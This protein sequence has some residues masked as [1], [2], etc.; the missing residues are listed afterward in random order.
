M[1]NARSWYFF[2]LYIEL[3]DTTGR[4]IAKWNGTPQIDFTGDTNNGGSYISYFAFSVMSGVS[5]YD[6]FIVGDGSGTVNTLPTGD[7]RVEYLVPNGV[8]AKTQFTPSAG[9][10]WGNV[11]ETGI[12]VD[13]DY[14]ASA[15]TGAVDLFPVSDLSG[16]GLIH[17]VQPVL[18][19]RK[20]DAGYR[21]IRPAFYKP[22]G[23]GDTPRLY[24]GT[25]QT[26][27]DNFAYNR[28]ILEF[29]PDTGVAWTTDEL[30]GM[31][32][33]YGVAGGGWIGVDAWIG[34]YTP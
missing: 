19:V 25:P 18:R 30:A 22:L 33:G 34:E 31:N 12:P 1:A 16:N 17:A 2:E 7:S 21:M 11:D 13:T 27:G 32:F 4:V 3:H 14:N 23:A 5:S 26:V 9:V 6:D 29:S 28:Q 20:D 24:G 15:V 10:N 8:G